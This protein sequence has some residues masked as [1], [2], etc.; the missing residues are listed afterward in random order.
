MNKKRIWFVTPFISVIIIL[1]AAGC[2]P[3]GRYGDKLKIAA[4][5]S[6]S[7]EEPWTNVIYQALREAERELEVVCTYSENVDSEAF[8]RKLRDYAETGYAVIFGEAYGNE[9]L[10]RKVARDYP[11]TVF[12]FGSGL[13]PSEPNL[14]V[15]DNWVHEPAYLCGL[16]AGKM[17][18]SG[19]IAVV[20]G[21]P[22]P[23]VN[24]LL[25]AFK[26]G[27]EELNPKAIVR[28]KFIDSW[29][30]PIRAAQAA[31]EEIAAGADIIYGERFG[32]IGVCQ[33]HDIIAF[34]NLQDQNSLAPDT[35]ITGPVWDMWPTV[36]RVIEDVREE[37]YGALDYRQWSMMA[38]GGA[39]LAAYHSFDG[40]IPLALKELVQ[41]RRR[42]ILAGTF[43]VL[44]D[45]SVPE[46]GLSGR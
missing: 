45:E 23:E 44:I 31:R 42:R 22:V 33:E 5:F 32:T 36:E 7:L 14:S 18:E 17:T 2:Q 34:G 15:F 21:K 16:I 4:V 37:K 19:I 13:S 10:V 27:V 40:R 25:N 35:V 41:Q 38:K 12:C 39:Y 6:S 30:D 29:F 20:A 8:E 3:S 11:E 24:R 46:S 28:F 1:F 43:R 26:R 9:D